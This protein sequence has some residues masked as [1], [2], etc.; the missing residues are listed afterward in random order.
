[1]LCLSP[2]EFE[3]LI[4]TRDEKEHTWVIDVVFVVPQGTEDATVIFKT[5]EPIAVK[6]P[7]SSG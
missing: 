3:N 5:Q 4:S 2:D 7:S 1:M 6:I